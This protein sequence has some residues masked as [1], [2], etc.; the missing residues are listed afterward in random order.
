[1]VIGE[2]M[3][4]LWLFHLVAVCLVPSCCD[5]SP[6]KEYSVGQEYAR[7]DHDEHNNDTS[8][9]SLNFYKKNALHA[10]QRR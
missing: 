2:M 4:A 8:V 9:N 10:H 7:K 3:F 1:M 6:N 5:E